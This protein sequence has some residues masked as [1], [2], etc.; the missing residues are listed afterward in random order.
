MNIDRVIEV[1]ILLTLWVEFWYD[2]WWNTRERRMKRTK[3][4]RKKHEFEN[5]TTGEHK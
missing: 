4:A 2:A 5:L 1:A 3:Q